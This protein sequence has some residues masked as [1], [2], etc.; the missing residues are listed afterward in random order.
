[1]RSSRVFARVRMTVEVAMSQPWSG[2][3]TVDN[4][5]KFAQRDAA[6]QLRRYCEPVRGLRLVSVDAL[7]LH[8]IEERDR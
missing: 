5:R 8:I 4:V 2:E 1:M 3:E 6:D 7:D